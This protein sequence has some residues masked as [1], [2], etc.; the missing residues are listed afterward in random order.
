MGP[1]HSKRGVSHAEQHKIPVEL[2]EMT[3]KEK[4]IVMRRM[5][6]DRNLTMERG[7]MAIFYLRVAPVELPNDVRSIILN[8]L[9][10]LLLEASSRSD[11]VLNQRPD[12]SLYG[13]EANG[14][15]CKKV[16]KFTYTE[17]A[18]KTIL[19]ADNNDR[20]QWTF[21]FSIDPEDYRKILLKGTIG[22]SPVRF[23]SITTSQVL[24]CLSQDRRHYTADYR[25]HIE[26]NVVPLVEFLW[27]SFYSKKLKKEICTRRL[28]E[29]LDREVS[30][31]KVL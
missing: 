29:K 2:G 25:T 8:L 9:I 7:S 17:L 19:L 10:T 1:A 15:D 14:Y 4:T 16:H 11:W 3:L 18:Q 21:S 12:P 20:S 23:D 31:F 24:D 13:A 6:R 27:G 22:R 5:V 28:Q 30:N 26:F